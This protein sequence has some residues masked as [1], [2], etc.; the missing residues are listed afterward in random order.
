MGHSLNPKVIAEG[1]ETA[2]QLEYLRRHHCDQ[3]QGYYFSRPV[4][5]EVIA[6]MLRDDK[7]LPE[8][9]LTRQV[10]SST[11]WRTPISSLTSAVGS[12]PPPVRRS[13]TG[14]SAG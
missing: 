6:Q 7:R 11:P 12:S 8:H 9:L 1:V 14:P 10:S 13:G 5:A 3:I 2:P 4:I